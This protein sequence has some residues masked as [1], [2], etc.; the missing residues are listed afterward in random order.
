[1]K[2][3]VFSVMII[4]FVLLFI[5]MNVFADEIPQWI[6]INAE[7]WVNGLI[8]DDTFVEGI[9]YLVNE[10][11]II[12]STVDSSEYNN[13]DEIP[14]WIKI[15]AEWWVNGLIDDDTFVEGIE[16]LIENGVIYIKSNSDCQNDLNKL[17]T[18]TKKIEKICN[19]FESIKNSEL[20]PFKK[21]L[22]FNSHGFYGEDFSKKKIQDEFRIIMVGD[23]IMIGGESSS[24]QTTIPGILQKMINHNN[25]EL[26]IE[27]INAGIS[28]S[29]SEVELEII[30]NKLIKYEP[31]LIIVYD[32]WNDLKAN[33]EYG[34]I[35]KNWKKMCEVGQ[36]NNFDVMIFLQPIAGF[37]D[38]NLTEQERINALTGI[39]HAEYQL[40]FVKSFYEYL[41]KKLLLLETQNCHVFDTRDVF[42]NVS[43]P[44]YWDQGHMSDTGNFVSADRFLK[45]LSKNYENMFNYDDKFLKI[46]SKYNHPLT[47]ELLFFEL[48]IN[49][50]YSKI[51]FVDKNYFDKNFGK[52]SDLKDEFGIEGIL[53]GK[54]LRKVD[55][56]NINLDGKDL[57]GANLSGQ[58]L[59]D[60]NLTNTIIRD[61]DLSHTNLEGKKFSG[62][63]LRGI[64][65]SYANM[66]NVDF[67]DAKFTKIFQVPEVS[68]YCTYDIME[69][70]DI[71]S[72]TAL[73]YI[74]LKEIMTNDSIFVDFTN[75]D[76]TNA[77]FTGS[78]DFVSSLNFADFTNADLTNVEI[79][80]M[81]IGGSIFNN[82][83][84][85][86]VKINSS[87][88]YYTDFINAKMK[89]FEITDSWFQSVSFKNA[90][91]V[92][93]IMN[94]STIIYTNFT[95]A[96]LSGMNISS[97]EFFNNI[98][99]CKNH[100]ICEK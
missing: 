32:G 22:N 91:M 76:L 23:S 31:N 12:V 42:D 10:N 7:W 34:I 78:R 58:D 88:L 59:R 20:I 29:T 77:E 57:T 15:N 44:V 9:E 4:G 70:A 33:T 65:F 17:F 89:N 98:Y 41:S 47:K 97:E 64:D 56:E 1:M 54:D 100:F 53:V 85:K 6:K 19:N 87:V 79:N 24:D 8:D 96:N 36:E 90:N 11:I 66:K 38:K 73:G 13:S 18:N 82:A 69:S 40:I 55:L 39:S 93:G 86:Q 75:A 14:Q 72:A 27:V 94:Q 25:P 48:G 46:I 60:I 49:V 26:K 63:D 81:G 5:P 50:D 52:Y 92:D 62:M 35:E 51:P 61:T 67:I 80:N 74:C 71:K 95:N 21:E 83:I 37:G 16:Y 2:G 68:N 43:G 84:L 99:N 30:K 28:G 45:E 3:L